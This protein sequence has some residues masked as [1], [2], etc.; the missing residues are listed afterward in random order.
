MA[1]I[2]LAPAD[3]LAQQSPPP[4]CFWGLP[5]PVSPWLP[6]PAVAP[7]PV[8]TPYMPPPV[9]R[10]SPPSDWGLVQSGSVRVGNASGVHLGAGAEAEMRSEGIGFSI[11]ML[12][13]AGLDR[14]EMGFRLS[15]INF[16]IP[17][18]SESLWQGGYLRWSLIEFA[19]DYRPQRRA[20]VT[21]D[22]NVSFGYSLDISR[23]FA[24][25]LIEVGG[26]VAVYSHGKSDNE[27][28]VILF[29]GGLDVST[30]LVFR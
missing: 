18:W 10:R 14:H 22:T 19:G 9:Q 2:V 12:A 21:V 13:T 26:Y 23:D 3:A 15:P 4:G 11:R 1:T 7:A 24:L 5:C 29:D 28:S 16:H 17:L 25:R 27:A 30:G 8:P 6:Q 20:A